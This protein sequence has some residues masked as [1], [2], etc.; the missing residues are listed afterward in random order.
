MHHL[1]KPPRREW[2][3]EM[4]FSLPWNIIIVSAYFQKWS[5]GYKNW[6]EGRNILLGRLTK[7]QNVSIKCQNTWVIQRKQDQRGSK[8]W[9]L[10]KH[11]RGSCIQDPHPPCPPMQANVSIDVQH[12]FALCGSDYYAISNIWPLAFLRQQKFRSAIQYTTINQSFE[13]YSRALRC[14]KTSLLGFIV[15][16]LWLK[17]NWTV[18]QLTFYFHRY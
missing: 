5:A 13:F 18:I 8:T 12:H 11:C 6:L 4:C 3:S 16:F 14:Y 15:L 9:S 7:Q 2:M 1:A 17:V 10:D